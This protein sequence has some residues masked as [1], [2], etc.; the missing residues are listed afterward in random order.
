MRHPWRRSLVVVGLALA[1]AA[2]PTRAR[3]DEVPKEYR[4]TI[5]KGLDYLART[6]LPDGQ[7]VGVGGDYAIPMTSLAGM[8][9]L[10]EGSTLGEGKYRGHLRRAVRYLLDRCQGNG[11]I[12]VPASRR[13]GGSYLYGHGFAMTFL[14]SC[15]GDE[16]DADT[17]AELVRVL[18]RP[19]RSGGAARTTGGAGGT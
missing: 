15:V 17:R 13:E 14:A 3:A 10:A 2:C 4:A 7:W 18:E 9:L 8:A 6:Q 12:G 11:L 16:R 1:L 19:A 5:N